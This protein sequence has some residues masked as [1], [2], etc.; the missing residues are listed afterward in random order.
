M[1]V[2]LNGG[3][4]NQ[5]FQ[6]AFGRSVSLDRKELLFFEPQ[7]L[8]RGCHR[9]YSLDA[10]KVN[11]NW[12]NGMGGPVYG[13][14]ANFRYDP[15]VYNADPDSF[16]KG[17]W[18]T[19]KYFTNHE[20]IIRREFEIRTPLH[21]ETIKVASRIMHGPSAFVHVR[22]TDYMKPHAVVYHGNMTREYYREAMNH[23]RERVNH[24]QFYIFSDEPQWCRGAFD[25]DD[26]T[27]VGHNTMGDGDTGP[28]T[29]HE[30]IY[31]MSL[32]ENGI[33]ANSSFSWWG[34]WLGDDAKRRPNRIVIGPQKWFVTPTLDSSDIM[35]ERWIKL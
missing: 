35:P 17:C 30:D 10:F 14:L 16:F 24:V 20:D 13:E 11:V 26:T 3:M 2:R 29:E 32:C 8:G 5:M 28:G 7:D 18:Q 15:F 9:A 1:I 22:R 33:M 31:L 25:D 34:A 6:Y 4:C 19:E 23:I 27:I 12:A 21:A